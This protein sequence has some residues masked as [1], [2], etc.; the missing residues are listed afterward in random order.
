MGLWVTSGPACNVRVPL[1]TAR[2]CCPVLP[3]SVT[4]K[5]FDASEWQSTVLKSHGSYMYSTG[6]S[7]WQDAPGSTHPDTCH[8]AHGRIGGFKPGQAWGLRSAA[9][10]RG[11]RKP[12]GKDRRRVD[13]GTIGRGSLAHR[14]RSC[15]QMRATAYPCVTH[16]LGLNH[17]PLPVFNGNA[18]KVRQVRREGVHA[19]TVLLRTRAAHVSASKLT[20]HQ[21]SHVPVGV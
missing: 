3:C 5:P 7:G 14:K 20:P 21:A 6:S 9:R 16:V 13:S 12:G 19:G 2:G 1:C 11:P 4:H 15:P 8:Q 18:A 17:A 10:L